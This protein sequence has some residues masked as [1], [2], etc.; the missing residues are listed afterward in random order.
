VAT[1]PP[2]VRRRLEGRGG[3]GTSTSTRGRPGSDCPSGFFGVIS[4]SP[5]GKASAGPAEVSDGELRFLPLSA[6]GRCERAENSARSFPLDIRGSEE[7]TL[8]GDGA[9]GADEDSSSIV[10]V[11]SIMVSACVEDHTH[12]ICGFWVRRPLRY[13]PALPLIHPCEICTDINRSEVCMPSG[14]DSSLCRADLLDASG[15]EYRP[16]GSPLFSPSRCPLRSHC[17]YDGVAARFLCHSI[18]LQIHFVD[19]S[20]NHCMSLIVR[21]YNTMTHQLIQGL[22]IHVV[23]LCLGWTWDRRVIKPIPDSCQQTRSNLKECDLLQG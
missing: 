22:H 3:E 16:V 8:R 11:N 15:G 6:Y 1:E 9:R 18:K 12:T 21:L 19:C 2:S 13:P 7:G 17:L 5:V 20:L 14:I 23:P 4:P 10:T